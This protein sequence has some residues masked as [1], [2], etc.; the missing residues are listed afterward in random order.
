[1]QKKIKHWTRSSGPTTFVIGY[2]RFWLKEANL[3]S[4]EED[5]FWAEQG[6]ELPTIGPEDGC[7]EEEQAALAKVAM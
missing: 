6:D 5:E 1:M 4:K 2:F 3:E 7:M